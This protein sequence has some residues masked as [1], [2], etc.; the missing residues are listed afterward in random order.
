MS[1]PRRW[2]VGSLMLAVAA[3]AVALAVARPRPR[4]PPPVAAGLP[5]LRVAAASPEPGAID[6]SAMA[7]FTATSRDAVVWFAVDVRRARPDGRLERAWAHR[8]DGVL[9]DGT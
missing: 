3:A 1:F 6:V 5:G 9:P 8:F 2:T 4:P 7:R